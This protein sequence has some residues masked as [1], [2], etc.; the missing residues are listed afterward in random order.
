VILAG[1]IGGTKTHLALYAPGSSAREPVLERIYASHDF[2]SL[3]AAV[4]AFLAS[5]PDRDVTRAAFGI[6]G[7]VR[8]NRCE[9][10]NLPWHVDGGEMSSALS[11][12]DVRL[13]N[14]LVTTASGLDVLKSADFDVLQAG[15]RIPGGRAV[16]AAGTGLGMVAEVREGE[17]F[18]VLASE[19]GH[20]DFAP[21]TT[22]EDELAGWLR[23]RYGRVSVER[24]LS[25]RGL[26]DIYRFLSERGRGAEPP[27][28]AARFAASTDPAALVGESALAGTCERAKLAVDIFMEAYGS[29]AGNLA[30]RVLPT[31]G[32]FIGGG[33]VP[34]LR[35]AFRDTRFLEA[36]T[37]KPPMTGMLASIPVALI[38]EPQTALWGAAE[39]ALGPNLEIP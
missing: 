22:L 34:R 1:D 29:E 32:L 13:F 36:L 7:V 24:V 12:A 2:A 5:H 25:G 30:L 19:G 3:E 37:N 31:E 27:D 9:T 26:A 15:T 10:T 23:A 21:R 17:R 38:L 4:S 8:G 35:A 39:L 20:A 18:V 14:D 28:F 16:L 6:A 11:G 33:N